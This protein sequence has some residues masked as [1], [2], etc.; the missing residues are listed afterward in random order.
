MSNEL[1]T[2]LQS[3]AGNV[4]SGF[5]PYTV[6][7]SARFNDNDSAYLYRTPSSSGSQDA[8][9]ISVWVKRGN[10]GIYS[11]IF[12]QGNSADGN[13]NNS[14]YAYWNTD[15]SIQF[16]SETSGSA[17]GRVETTPLYRDS[18]GWY[19]LVFVYDSANATANDRMRIYV[20]GERVTALDINTMPSQNA[21]SQF[22]RTDRILR[23]GGSAGSATAYFADCYFSQYVLVDG[24]ALDPTS[25][26]ESKNGIWVPKDVSGLTFGTNGFY[27]DFADSSALGNDVSGNNNDFTSSGLT[28]SDQM[29]D[30]P[31]NNFATLNPLARVAGEHTFSDGNMVDQ[32]TCG[33]AEWHIICGTIAL[34][35]TG[36]YYWETSVTTGIY[37]ICGLVKSTYQFNSMPATGYQYI[38]L[39]T[40]LYNQGFGYGYDGS[41]RDSTSGSSVSVATG[42]TFTTND[43]IG[44]AVDMDNK[45]IAFYKN[46]TLVTTLTPNTFTDDDSWVPAF[47]TY[48]V[49]DVVTVNF[50]QLGFTYTPPTDFLALST[51]NLPEPTIGPNSTTKTDEVFAPILYTGNGTS[52]SISTLEFQPDFTWIKDRDT[53]YNHMLF[54]VLRGATKYLNSNTINAEATDAQSLSSFNSNGFSVGNNVA[55]NTNTEDYV[56]WNWKANGSGVSN[57]DGSIT[58]TV[59]ANQDAG[60]SIVSYTGNNSASATVGHGLSSSAAMIL[61]KDRDVGNN[62]WRAWHKDLTTNYWMYLNLTNAQASAALDGG[63]RNVDSSTFGFIN[64]TT[65][66]VEAVNRTGG[67]FI[68]YCFSEVEGFSSFGSYTGNGSSDGPMIFTGMRPAFVIVKQS[69]VAR[70]WYIFDSARDTYNA[71]DD[72]LRADDSAAE[73][74]LDSYDFLSN[75]FKLRNNNASFNQS[76]GTYIYMAFAENPFKYSNAR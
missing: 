57:T 6:D 5:Y 64:G 56:A 3:A 59:S 9:T 50:G 68:A 28:S 1:I 63:L 12:W 72:Y 7:Y 23:L 61:L 41:T 11:S 54:D 31:T 74:N 60:I 35:S 62:N 48:N 4:S 70:G 39:N 33:L 10:Q 76:G 30:T 73:A 22:N 36:K 15:N 69:N 58:S 51:A 52:Q 46:N 16:I 47:C 53:A 38:G 37:L 34:P 65:Q 40:E 2:A 55:V 44:I 26:G 18:S 42:T 75:G 14:T 66:G 71:V 21:D 13:H 29:A 20:N 19:H 25:F 49:N 43:V 17:V 8:T 32:H 24:Q 67:E 45:T 27:L